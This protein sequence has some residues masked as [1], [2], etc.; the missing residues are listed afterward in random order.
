M[1]DLGV[2]SSAQVAGALRQSQ[3]LKSFNGAPAVAATI[4][5][6]ISFGD[7]ISVAST[8]YGASTNLVDIAGD[9]VHPSDTGHEKIFRRFRAALT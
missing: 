8:N 9:F 3:L 4:N 6:L 2:F 1:G 5:R 7:S